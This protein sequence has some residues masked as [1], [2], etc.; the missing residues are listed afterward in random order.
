[1]NQAFVRHLVG[2]A[3]R[4]L[5]EA[6]MQAKAAVTDRDVQRTWVLLG[7]PTLRLQS[8]ATGAST[9]PDTP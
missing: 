1:M 2:E 5:G 7:D 4:T 3:G 9:L 8:P 6:I